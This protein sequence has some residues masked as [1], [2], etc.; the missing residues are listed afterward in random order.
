VFGASWGCSPCSCCPG[1][2][3]Y[4]DMCH[5]ISKM[6]HG[7]GVHWSTHHPCCCSF[8]SMANHLSGPSEP[9]MDRYTDVLPYEHNRVRLES[10][11]YINASRVSS[12]PDDLSAPWSF[13]ATQGPLPRESGPGGRR[14]GGREGGRQCCGAPCLN[15]GPTARLIVKVTCQGY[16]GG[17]LCRVHEHFMPHL[18]S[19]CLHR[20]P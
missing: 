20:H 3:G 16:L 14:E 11:A 13:I 19:T 9:R 1:S 6:R 18:M 5:T 15:S 10:G 7:H 12:E 4:A 17:Y 2:M 8:N